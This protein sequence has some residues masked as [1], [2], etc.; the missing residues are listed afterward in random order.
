MQSEQEFV[1]GFQ[2][3]FGSIQDE[4]QESKVAYP[5]IEILFVVVVGVAMGSGN[6]STIELI[7][8]SK[9]DHLRKYYPFKNG[10]PSDDTIRRLIE[11]MCPKEL[12]NSLGKFF[13]KD[14]DLDGQNVAIDGKTLKGSRR[15]GKKAAHLLNVYASGSGITLFTK[16]VDSKT[17]EITAIPD[18]IDLL[19]LSG[20]TVTID[21]MGCQKNI[22]NK[23]V[24]KGAD[25]IFGLKGNQTAL[26]SEVK[27]LFG[28]NAEK[29][30]NMEIAETHD[31]G[32]G[33][34]E[35]RTCR[36]VR[37]LSKVPSS[38]DWKNMKC[39][40]EII[41]EIESK[42]KVTSS[43]NYYIS[44]SLASSQEIMKSIRDHWK[45]ESMHWSL[46]VVFKEDASGM[47]K[48][49]IPAN[50]GIV[51]RFVFNI[52]DHLREKRE[53]KPFLMQKIRE[54]PEYLHKFIQK[55]G[56]DS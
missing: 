50:M 54:Y 35:K 16:E 7:G 1:E 46:D 20:A 40:I 25:Y 19:D 3:C 48:G 13:G 45:I 14:V 26:H 2:E 34:I 33:R 53:T 22:A 18:A 55:L 47:Y 43:T 44:S 10:S 23:I 31:K 39:A 15:E 24:E 30:F 5:L 27:D 42:G 4:R 51:R 21:A 28:T 17:N 38:K 6:W 56:F 41:S 32:H 37:D 11:K 8:K 29:F 49:N 9:I 12:N 36:V 52:L